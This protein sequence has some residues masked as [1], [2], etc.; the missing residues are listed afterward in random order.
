V[1]AWI[2]GACGGEAD[3]PSAAESGAA[4]WSSD[5]TSTGVT[6]SGAATDA[7]PSSAAPPAWIAFDGSLRLDGEAPGTESTL[8]WTAYDASQVETC[9]EAVAVVSARTTTPPEAVAYA[10]PWWSIDTAPLLECAEGAPT[11][12][13][14]GIAPWNPALTPAADH[15]GLD[16]ASLSS[17]LFDG[18]AAGVWLVGAAGYAEDYTTT[19]DTGQGALTR[20]WTLR[21]LV[22]LPWTD[23]VAL[24]DSAP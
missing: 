19:L 11:T 14:V 22:L 4:T 3:A 5:A 13:G 18:G 16:P 1:V 2:L 15:A 12:L 21:G 8:S 20:T 9:T 23:V 24:A 6:D 7:P 17:L 10:S